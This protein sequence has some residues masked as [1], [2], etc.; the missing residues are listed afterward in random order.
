MDLECKILEMDRILYKRFIPDPNIICSGYAELND[1][2]SGLGTQVNS[3][4]CCFSRVKA[5]TKLGTFDF[6]MP[7]SMFCAVPA[8]LFIAN[9]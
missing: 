3:L 8:Q 2:V 4:F 6:S 7:V 9:S 1:S 5:S